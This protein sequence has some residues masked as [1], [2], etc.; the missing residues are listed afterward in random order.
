MI[1][2]DEALLIMTVNISNNRRI[3]LFFYAVLLHIPNV[4]ICSVKKDK[5]N[6]PLS[7]TSR[8]LSIVDQTSI[9]FLSSINSN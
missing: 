8:M 1:F 5:I 3:L 6:S 9:L 2:I 4:K 7:T